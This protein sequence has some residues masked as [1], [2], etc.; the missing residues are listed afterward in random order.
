MRKYIDS[1]LKR[2]NENPDEEFDS[3]KFKATTLEDQILYKAA[4][5]L[6]GYASKSN[7]ELL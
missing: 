2:Q 4:G 5:K 1:R 7:D 6:S 3:K